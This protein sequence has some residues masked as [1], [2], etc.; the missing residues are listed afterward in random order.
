[1]ALEMAVFDTVVLAVPSSS[2][3]IQF[4]ITFMIYNEI[5]FGHVTYEA[6]NISRY[7]VLVSSLVFNISRC[8]FAQFKYNDEREDILYILLPFLGL[9]LTTS[10]LT[11]TAEFFSKEMSSLQS[12]CSAIISTVQNNLHKLLGSAGFWVYCDNGIFLVIPYLTIGIMQYNHD[13][14][15]RTNTFRFCITLWVM[16]CWFWVKEV[17]KRVKKCWFDWLVR[18]FW[19]IRL[20]NMIMRVHPKK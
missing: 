6:H 7:C 9:I 18:C 13:Y 2:V 20:K 12:S 3:C 16:F 5:G 1:M 4:M 11:S 19:Y 15:S 8:S 10:I 14:W 17:M